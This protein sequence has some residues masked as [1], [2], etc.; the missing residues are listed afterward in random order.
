MLEATKRIKC[1][2]D[3]KPVGMNICDLVILSTSGKQEMR[4]SAVDV[5]AFAKNMGADSL[6]CTRNLTPVLY[7]RKP[8]DFLT[9]FCTHNPKKGKSKI[10]ERFSL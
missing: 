8:A 9:F 6:S 7:K 1:K 4:T 10:V 3:S 5:S 2:R